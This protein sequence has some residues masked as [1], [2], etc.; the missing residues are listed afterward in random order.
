MS[1]GSFGL[2]GSAG[3]RLAALSL[4]LGAVASCR[5]VSTIPAQALGPSSSAMPVATVPTV[6]SDL[7]AISDARG[8]VGFIDRQ[9]HMVVA[10]QFEQVLRASEGLSATRQ[11]GLWGFLDGRGKWAIPA[12]FAQAQPFS[13]GQAAAALP[14]AGEP[15]FGFIDHSGHWSIPPRFRTATAFHGGFASVTLNGVAA[16]VNTTGTVA[17]TA[18]GEAGYDFR[19][20]L[21]RFVSRGR[22]GFLNAEGQVAIPARFDDAL[23]F[24]DGL[25]AVKVEKLW[26]FI[27]SSGTYRIRPRF[28]DA[29]FFACGIAKI[30]LNASQSGFVDSHGKLLGQFE[31]TSDCSN[32]Y[33]AIMKG[34][35]WGF[36]APSGAVIVEPKFEKF[37]GG[38]AE[39]LAAVAEPG[40][41]FGYI[42]GDGRYVIEPRFTGAQAFENGFAR[43]E[44]ASHDAGIT[45]VG[46]IDRQGRLV[47]GP[48][49]V[50]R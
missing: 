35:R 42:G 38:F 1:L 23:D 2:L 13:E 18:P 28:I 32:G 30:A 11:H 43:I 33:A 26:G 45:E 22:M 46:Y 10:P 14:G 15:V 47:W 7:I 41:P 17:F 49:P 5:R 50:T 19:D 20:G 34:N 3:L 12:L 24:S 40:R 8:E 21:A 31:A 39:E 48:F 25:A 6:A 29:S 9:G 16:Y 37:E 27:D 4:V 44:Q 36:M